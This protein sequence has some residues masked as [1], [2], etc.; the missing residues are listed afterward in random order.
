VEVDRPL[1]DRHLK[2]LEVGVT[3][4]GYKTKP[5]KVK[6]L[7]EKKISITLTEG[8][9]HQIRRMIAA[10]GPAVRD[11]KRVRIMNI[12]LEGIKQNAMREIQDAELATLLKTI[13][14]V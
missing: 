9:K 8:K 6:R 5:T 10:L 14:L 3:I 1:T 4:E 7:G 12:K 13:K 2:L 11:L